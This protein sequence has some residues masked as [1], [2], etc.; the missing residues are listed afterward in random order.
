ML[1][2]PVLYK[3]NVNKKI[4]I[5]KIIIEENY[6]WTEFG[7][8]DGTIQKSDKV[9][10]FGKNKGKKNET[11]DDQQAFLEAKSIWLKKIEKENFVT[12][13]EDVADISFNPPMLAKVYDGKYKEE[14]KFI[15]PKL[16]GVRCNIS[17]DENGEINAISRKNKKFFS[18]KHI[19]NRLKT[20]FEKYPDLHLDGELYNHE[21][22]DDFNKIVSLVKKQK[23]N[24]SDR[25][26]IE[27]TVMYYVYDA[28]FDN[29]SSLTFSERFKIIKN[30]LSNLVY[31]EIV[32][33]ETYEIASNDDIE[34]YFNKFTNNGYEGAIIR[35]DK[36]YEHKR[37]K[38]LLKYKKFKDDEF[39]VISV[40]VGKTNTIA[41]SITIRLKNGNL[42]NATLAFT[43]EKCKEILENK[44]NYIGK[45]ATVCYFGE[46]NDG[47]LRFPVVKSFNRN[48]YE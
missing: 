23:I 3:L 46:T 2:L 9:Y 10:C 32:V 7:L 29:D 24:E 40:N 15:Q 16:D 20:V 28:W 26:N 1:E 6:Y 44:E 19:E 11:R 25:N 12:F 34:Y 4:N 42:C 39:E 31:P 41:E 48:E 36:P 14:M 21:L 30:V 33:V 43:D 27:N 8:L 17:L 18:T 22:H 13:I 5:W 38:N 47:M 45:L 37:S 35:I